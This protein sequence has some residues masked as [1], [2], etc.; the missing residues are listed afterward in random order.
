[1]RTSPQLSSTQRPSA[2]VY[3]YRYRR[4]G[5]RWGV[6]DV[7]AIGALA[8]LVPLGAFLA[9]AAIGLAQLG[10]DGTAGVGRA[11]WRSANFCPL[12]SVGGISSG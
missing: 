12:A 1:M 11:S 6:G 9:F 5:R 8:L 7:E 4:G 10:D 2:V 3:R